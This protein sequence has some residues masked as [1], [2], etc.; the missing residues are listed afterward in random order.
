MGV[1]YPM[2][3]VRAAPT[4][5]DAH[6]RVHRPPTALSFSS[7]EAA[8]MDGRPLRACLRACCTSAHWHRF[9]GTLPRAG[10][11]RRALDVACGFHSGPKRGAQPNLFI[12]IMQ[13]CIAYCVLA[14]AC[15]SSA[16]AACLFSVDTRVQSVSVPSTRTRWPHGHGSLVEET[17]HAQRASSCSRW[18]ALWPGF[19]QRPEGRRAPYF[20]FIFLFCHS[21]VRRL[22]VLACR[23]S[24]SRVPPLLSMLPL[25]R[26]PS[27]L[28]H[29]A[30]PAALA[31]AAL[32]AAAASGP[33][34]FAKRYRPLS[35]L[36]TR[37]SPLSPSS[38]PC[39]V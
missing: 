8:H 19:D 31:L 3:P 12:N 25:L 28:T 11:Q 36:A 27:L 16:A 15:C 37:C 18:L 10:L 38:L 4:S 1:A 5:T 7:G 14:S 13:A 20:F 30:A 32:A 2:L 33:Q 6:Y 35:L 24:A 21:I 26:A 23:A 22:Q 39:Q 29:T 9:K 34:S 17:P